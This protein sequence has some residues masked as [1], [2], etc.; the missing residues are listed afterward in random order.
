MERYCEKIKRLILESVSSI[1]PVEKT[2]ELEEHIE[3]CS[4]CREYLRE[5]QADDELLR[6]FTQAMQPRVSRL[7]SNVLD[8]MRRGI[9]A[10]PRHNY[11]I[12]RVIE[13]KKVAELVAATTIVLAVSV[14]L[15]YFSSSVSRAAVAWAAVAERVQKTS[16]FRF[17]H[18]ARVKSPAGT[19]ELESIVSNSLEYGM[20]QDT[21]VNREPAFI[22]FVPPTGN[23]TTRIW[24]QEKKYVHTSLT[25]EQLKHVRQQLDL[26]TMVKAFTSLEYEEL[27]S[28]M[29]DG[30]EVEGIQI[31]DR[32][33]GQGAFER[34]TGRLW[35]DREAGLPV[36][37]EVEGVSNGGLTEMKI[38]ADE[39]EWDIELQAGLFEPS[40][41]DDYSEITE[42]GIS[43]VAADIE[44]LIGGLRM[45]A[46]L[47]GGRYPSSL[48]ATTG[49][50]DTLE[51]Y[52]RKFPRAPD[53]VPGAAEQESAAL[54]QAACTIY[55]GLVKDGL[56]VAYYGKTVTVEFAEAVLVRWKLAQDQ[57]QVILADLSSEIVSAE[58]LGQLESR[59]L[60]TATAAIK[61]R[62]ADGGMAGAVRAL[63]LSWMPGIYA[64]GHEVYFG[65]KPDE[66]TL[67]AEVSQPTCDQLP[68]LET[69][70]TYY[71]RVDEIQPDGSVLAGQVWSFSTGKLLGW[72][73]FDQGSG[74]VTADSGPGKNDG[75]LNNMER[76]SWVEGISGQALEFD[77]V[78]DS[79][80]TSVEID[81]S[82]STSVTMMAWVYPTSIS[83]GR[84]QVISSDDGWWDWS[85]LREADRWHAFTG[86]G[87]WNSQFAVD[88]NQ[89]QHV[90]VVFEPDQDVIF[91]KNALAS[92]RGFAPV[93]DSSDNDI[94]IGNNPAQWDEYFQ[95][96]I[97][98]VRIYSYALSPQE[99]A[100]IHQSTGPVLPSPGLTDPK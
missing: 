38:V 25:D 24:T 87:S 73:R 81:Q 71:W 12:A 20:R 77:G 13:H 89:W 18:L 33:F 2:A 43:Y 86:D 36:R 26:R 61:P 92:S 45:F 16:A 59:P 69:D 17:R 96:L 90:A 44:V 64:V 6:Q 54:M 8:Q 88:P 21:Y 79:V 75:T 68:A 53:V 1:L 19:I 10:R 30:V 95:G 63:Q 40:I 58:Q 23:V 4:S 100:A 47:T 11:L 34:A 15:Y 85:L 82:G 39:F 5:V 41:P 94:V 66:L 57:Y 55:A 29:I 51:A 83:P 42:V 74:N 70:S 80:E 7:E 62:P 76:G 56:D 78:D 48:A 97:D 93:A 60:N 28:E 65:T 98:E 52:R 37:L 32:R 99:I 50:R 91:Y 22:L 84:H 35:A 67:L 9:P 49:V 46:E 72:W 31:D 14:W 27:G 3:R